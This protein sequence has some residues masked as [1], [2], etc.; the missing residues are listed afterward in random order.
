VFDQQAEHDGNSSQH[1][2][3][4]QVLQV[5]WQMVTQQGLA[6]A[7]ALLLRG[8]REGR[9]LAQMAQYEQDQTCVELL[10]GA[11]KQERQQAEGRRA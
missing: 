7:Q 6:L 10:A 11:W 8:T 4:W 3:H 5:H 1:A 2:V 9:S